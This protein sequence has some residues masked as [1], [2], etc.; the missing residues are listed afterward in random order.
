M[1]VQIAV[2]RQNIGNAE[3]AQRALNTTLRNRDLLLSTDH[4]L[5][6]R[7]GSAETALLEITPASSILNQLEVKDYFKSSS[8]RQ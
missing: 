2:L 6:M 4:I 8:V 3:R 1:W 7:K 5:S